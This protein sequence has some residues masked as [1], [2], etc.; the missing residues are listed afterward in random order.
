MD[1]IVLDGK[2]VSGQ[3][4]SQL[5]Q[6][7]TK[8]KEHTQLVPKLTII[9]VG[10]NAASAV[11]I[12]NKQRAC[13]SIG[14]H[15]KLFHLAEDTSEKDLLTLIKQ[16]NHDSM[17]NGIIVQL[18]LPQQIHTPNILEAIEVG[19]DVDGFHPY[20][21]GRLAQKTPFLRPCTPMGIMHLLAAYSID[22]KGLNALVVGASNI[23]G[24][25]MS[26]ELLMAGATV[27]CAHSQT[28]NLSEH[29][30]H[31]DLIVMATGK[32]DLV[33]NNDFKANAIVIDV[34]IHRD[35]NGKLRGDIDFQSLNG[36]V[37]YLT[38]VPG[39]VGP[40]TVACLLKNTLFAFEYQ[41]RLMNNE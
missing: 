39:G 6:Q 19:K 11:Y 10:D 23:V 18:P 31:A 15:S 1:S 3:L 37:A 40:M 21:I 7:V 30:R 2:Q 25:P 14:M 12:K 16:L 35:V 41:H 8:L 27:T 26:L 22:V 38:P 36:K 28:K 4:K 33:K 32:Q 9:Q 24:K 29:I 5:S 13:E 17:V 34:G 20:N